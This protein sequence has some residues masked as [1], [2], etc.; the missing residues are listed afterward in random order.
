MK[1][2]MIDLGHYKSDS[3]AVGNGFKEVDLNYSIGKYVGAALIRSGVAVTYAEG[4][5]SDRTRLENR[6]RP[7]AFVS[8]HNNAGGGDGTE[9]YHYPSSSTGKRLAT[10]ILN[11]V[12]NAGLNNSRGV[13]SANFH[14]L[15]ETV[16]VAALIECAFMDTSDIQA[17]DEEHERKAFG[18]AIAKGICEYLGVGYKTE[19]KPKPNPVPTGDTYY[20][21]VCGSFKDRNNAEKR[22]SELEKAG[23]TGVFL[24]SFKK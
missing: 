18:E 14:V 24:D 23:F 2:T 15:R 9:V 4:S 1:H 17:V 19:E 12:I 6:I 13:K 11:S 3:G 7:D 22:K 16:S 21:V 5:L 10:C 20:R 8:V